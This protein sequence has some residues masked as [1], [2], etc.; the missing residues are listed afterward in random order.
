MPQSDSFGFI[1]ND[2]A[3]AKLELSRDR[4]Q[5]AY[6]EL[7]GGYA[8]V[9][10]DVLNETVRVEN[11]AGTVSVEGISFYTFCEHHF[12]PFFGL[13]TITYKPREI[14]TGIGKLIRLVKYV[15]SRRLQI[16]EIMAKDICDDIIRVL[17]AK[18]VKVTLR[19]KHLCTCSR[20]P[21][22]D[23]SMTEVNYQIGSLD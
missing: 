4:I 12:L 7:L 18:G 23:T 5:R 10:E 20:G 11:Y 16:Q 13:A 6:G 14:I 2:T 22:D 21:S 9:A 19:A 15:H 8:L 1:E 3:R 17:D